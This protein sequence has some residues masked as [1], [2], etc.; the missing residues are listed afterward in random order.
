MATDGSVRTPRV[1]AKADRQAALL[2]EAARLF[3]A[4]G[5][6]GVS[7]EDLGASV[8]VT[9]PAIYRHFSS[10]RALLGAILVR[11]SEEL[12]DGGRTVE[13]ETP[14]PTERLDRLIAFHVDFALSG[15][16]VIRVHDRELG[17]LSD[18]DRRTVR[19]LQRTYV[20]LWV[21]VL[22]QLHPERPRDDLRV[23]AHANFGLINST[24]YSLRGVGDALPDG[25]V[26]GILESRARAALAA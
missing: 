23:R 6:D 11:V 9:G 15:A 24:S 22:A 20:A 13:E 14:D 12:L 17:S 4:R 1:R 26:R 10:K 16:D 3:A 8:G 7:L 25:A 19:T 5:F 21:D 2:R 18:A